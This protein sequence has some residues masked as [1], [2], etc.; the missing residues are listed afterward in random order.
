MSRAPL[1]PLELQAIAVAILAVLLLWVIR[2]VRRD[3]MSLRDSLLWLLSTAVALGLMA[4][5]EGL[6]W[7]ADRLGVEV[8]SNALFALGFVYV[9]LNLLSLTI[10]VSGGAAR[11]RRLAQ[12]CAL[13]RGEIEELRARLGDGRS[14]ERT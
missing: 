11:T 7:V 2:L 13:L 1:L 3:R 9:L 10:A 8:A 4:F 14:G 6:R 5:P 12:E